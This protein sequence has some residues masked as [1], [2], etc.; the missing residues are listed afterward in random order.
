MPGKKALVTIAIGDAYIQPWKTFCFPGWKQYAD[1]HGYDIVLITDMLDSGPL[2]TSRSPSWQRLLI[3]NHPSIAKYS[4]VVWMDADIAIN[5]DAAPCIV[6]CSSAVAG[7]EETVGVVLEVPSGDTKSALEAAINKRQGELKQT[8]NQGHTWRD[9]YRLNGLATDL[10]VGFNAGVMVLRPSQHS[11][12]LREV[13]EQYRQTP[14]SWLEGVPLAYHLL[15]KGRIHG[16][17]AA[18]NVNA[19]YVFYK[20]YPF[21]LGA[22]SIDS[23]L[24]AAVVR[25]MYENAY[26]L[27]F[28]GGGVVRHAMSYVPL[29]AN[30]PATGTF[31]RGKG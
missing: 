3:L 4:E 20:H 1:K 13:Y 31:T 30:I 22:S 29:P 26:F 11:N 23:T 21:L 9:M 15:S 2:G 16:I 24:M 17:P 12:L 14:N 5:A 25:T 27:H 28:L 19:S 8:L 6:D 7:S 18:F 10:D